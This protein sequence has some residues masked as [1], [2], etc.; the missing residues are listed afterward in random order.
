[1][2]YLLKSM[3]AI[4]IITLI[5]CGGK[6]EKKEDNSIKIGETPKTETPNETA[7]ESTTKP[8]ETVDLTNKGVGPIKNVTLEVGS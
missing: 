4:A 1:M 5:G 2:K 7:P 8:S 3:A 6:G